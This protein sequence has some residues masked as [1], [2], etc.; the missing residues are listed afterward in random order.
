MALSSLLSANHK[1]LATSLNL[2]FS[3][4]A[5]VI[6]LL[7]TIEKHRRKELYEAA[8]LE[9]RQLSENCLDVPHSFAHRLPAAGR[10]VVR[11]SHY[12][13]GESMYEHA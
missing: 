9:I 13:M 8:F 11:L 1:F 6:P 2:D 12:A 5:L 10:G 4:V 3:D 7:F